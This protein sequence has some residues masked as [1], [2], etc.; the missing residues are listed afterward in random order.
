MR[1]A[2]AVLLGLAAARARRDACPTSATIQQVVTARDD[3]TQ[4]LSPGAP[5]CF[6]TSGASS[7]NATVLVAHSR[8]GPSVIGFGGAFTEASAANFKALD[9]SDQKTFVGLYWGD[10]SH[11]YTMGRIPIQSCDFT[12]ATYSF[13]E[14]DGV[15]DPTL[16]RFDTNVTQDR[17]N[18]MIDL[19]NLALSASDSVS[20]PLFRRQG[21]VDNSSLWLYG[22]P[23]SPPA[24]MKIPH[25]GQFGQGM[26]GSASPLGLIQTDIVQR[27]WAQFFTKW[28][29]AY[30]AA[31]IPISAVTVQNEPQ[32]LQ[33]F[34]SC[35]YTPEAERDFLANYLGP[36]LEQS[37][38]EVEIWVW[39]HNRY[40][41]DKSPSEQILNWATTIFSDPQA[42]KYAAALA[43]HWCVLDR[44]IVLVRP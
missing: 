14:P 20:N 13:D 33:R 27:A 25:P 11:M 7:P 19:I 28:L 29:T 38:P 3:S 24:W 31:G 44:Q 4:R 21:A 12:E 10:A 43:F 42:R 36:E 2:L 6:G 15:A 1:G 23:W 40:G 18:G 22:S 26:N 8:R 32:A 41:S 17:T 37:H 30:D 35:L 34:E 16:A 9:P 39:D 5:L